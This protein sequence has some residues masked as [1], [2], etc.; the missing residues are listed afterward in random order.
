MSLLYQGRYKSFAV[1]ADDHLFILG[2]YVERN[3]LR[4]GLVE[5][6]ELWP[7]GSLWQRVHDGLEIHPKIAAAGP[8]DGNGQRAA[9]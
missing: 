5:R 2:R 6:A 3:A 4:A 8:V 9:N 7:W 1:E